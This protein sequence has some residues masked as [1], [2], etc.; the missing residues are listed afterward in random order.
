MDQTLPEF[1]EPKELGA[2]ALNVERSTPS[3]LREVPH[4]FS[5]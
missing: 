5:C 1:V 2:E 4:G 3:L